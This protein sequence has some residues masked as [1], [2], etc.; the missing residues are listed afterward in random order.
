MAVTVLLLWQNVSFLHAEEISVKVYPN[1]QYQIIEG[2]GASLCWWAHMVGQWDNEAK[3]DEV[4]DLITSPDKLNMNIF[5]YN[6]G[7]G[8]DPSHYST[9]ENPGHMAKGKGVRA[10]MQG[11]KASESSEYDWSKDAGQRKI[12]LKIKEKRSDAVFEAFSNS[13][14]YWMTFSGCSGG[15][16]PG[17]KDNLK[18]EYYGLFCDY[19]KHYRNNYDIEFKTL[20]PFNESLSSYW[21]YM[22]SQEGCHFDAESQIKLL[23]ILYPKLKSSGLKTLVSASDKTDL[24]SSITI[25]HAYMDDEDVLDMISQINVHTYSGSNEERLEANVL[26]KRIGKPFWQ[27]ETGQFEGE[28]FTNNLLLAQKCFDDLR[29]MKP[30]AWLDWQ[31]ME[32]H[33]DTWCTIK[34]NFANETF[35]PN[36]N[37]YVRMQITRFIKQGYRIIE[38][39]QDSFLAAISPDEKE[40]VVCCINL[41]NESQSIKCDLSLFSPT[42]SVDLYRTDAI[43]NCEKQEP[44]S[45]NEKG[46]LKF[47]TPGLSITTTVMRR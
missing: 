24:K 12:M 11:F 3:I 9:L 15:N 27:S 30:Q 43:T 42:Q 39:D 31:V 18:P 8:D 41:T 13:P 19:L 5:R 33:N 26:T 17:S 37:F 28:G 38:T 35:A 47:E 7:G 14:P 44:V 45:M 29:F 2:W 1:R 4:V 34:G 20:E 36:K 46:I 22:G 6:I 25:L 40:L 10:E 21:Y 23:K 16:N 32:E